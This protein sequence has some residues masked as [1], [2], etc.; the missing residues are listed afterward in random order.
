MSS[1][2]LSRATARTVDSD[3]DEVARRLCWWQ[4]PAEARR[5]VVRF[6]AQVMALGTDR[7]VETL[8]RALGE[9]MFDRVLDAPPPGLFS[10][11]RWNYWHVRRRRLPTPALPVR[12]PR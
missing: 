7:D 10:P 6:A 3:L 5:D 9:E 2:S 12:F 11:R 1:E 8:A 4:S